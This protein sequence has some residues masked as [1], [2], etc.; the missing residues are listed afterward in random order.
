LLAGKPA[1]N[2]KVMSMGRLMALSSPRAGGDRLARGREA[3][4]DVADTLPQGRPHDSELPQFI[5]VLR[6]RWKVIAGCTAL[7]TLVA[8]TVVFQLAPRYT[9]ETTVMLD[10]RKTQVV[11]IQAVVSG[12]QSDAAVVRSEVEVL[13]SADLASRVVRK[14]NLL[15]D[16]HTNPAL[17]PTNFWSRIDPAAWLREAYERLSAREE[18]QTPKT[19]E[20][21]NADE[22]EG[23]IVH[24]LDSLVVINDGR[25]YI[26]KIRYESEDPALSARIANTYAD[27]YL[28]QQLETKFDATKRAT[29]W[30]DEHLSKLRDKVVESDQAAQNFREQHQLTATKGATITAQQLTE[31]NS[32]LILA[33]ADRAQ[34]E[35]NL[36]Q[37]QEML[38]SSGGADAAAQVLA[39][40]VI[41]QLKAQQTEL[42]RKEA[43]LSTRY[44]PLHP[45]MINIHAQI[46]DLNKKIQEEGNNIVHSMQ[47]DVNAA[48][49]REASLRESLQSLQKSTGTQNQDEVTLRQLERESEANRTLYENFLSRFKQT[50]AQEDM[51][52]ADAHIVAV[53][54]VPTVPT[55]PRKGM[56]TGLAFTLALMAGI[57]LAF[58][59]ERLDNGFRD[60]DQIERITGVPFIGLVPAVSGRA[61]DIVVKKPI[62]SYG[63]AIRSVRAAL[64]FTNI[65]HPPKVVLVTSSVPKEGK[66]VFANSLARSVACSGG[67]A[68]IIDCDLRHPTQAGLLK[69]PKSL[70]LLSYFTEG[71][72][73]T[74][75]IQVD[76]MSR[77][78][79]LPVWEGATNP[80]DLLGSQQMKSLLDGLRDKYDLIV[81]DAPPVLAVSDAL[82]LSHLV[83]A[84]LFLVRWAETPRPV[85]LGAIKLL[86]TQ[87]SGVAG[88]VMSRVDVR[89]HAKYGYGD[90]GYYYGRYGAYYAS[91]Q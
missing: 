2:E 15:G 47:N 81:L 18:P 63:E 5:G 85:S 55:F 61:Q 22:L 13:K 59:L 91:K 43:E 10:T 53:A 68:L 26:I 64:N 71:I 11:D 17:M 87:G 51:Q 74:R 83:D 1:M 78:H 70:G 41:Q 72:D 58:T 57:A 21:L 66:S 45:E 33:S 14:L 3:E 79:Y 82:V 88:F 29:T 8:V 40:P 24:V 76:E 12:L 54:Q 49:T 37:I 44:K 16:K 34:K 67:R 28:A 31:I 65:D 50:S 46:N 30:L 69:A 56:L 38:K 6:R 27:L 9:A 86:R 90:A 7:L 23:V 84:T 39:S 75:L 20:E 48:R 62:S 52:Q 25:S 4:S 19:P 32:Q 60:P 80:Q 89:Q 42:R 73:P 35:A 77:V 36:R